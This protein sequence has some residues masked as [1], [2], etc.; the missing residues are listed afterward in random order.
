[1]ILDGGRADDQLTDFG[2]G[3]FRCGVARLVI[4]HLAAM[5]TPTHA[6]IGEFLD[7]ILRARER[8]R[9]NCWHESRQRVRRAFRFR[10]YRCFSSLPS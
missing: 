9:V 5:Q 7:R 10:A 4:E 3:F 6:E 1:M 2:L 8:R